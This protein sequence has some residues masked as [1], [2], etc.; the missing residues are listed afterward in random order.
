M[1]FANY[2]MIY[3][4]KSKIERKN[5]LYFYSYETKMTIK[6]T[7]FKCLKYLI[8]VQI[9]WFIIGVITFCVVD[10]TTQSGQN[11]AIDRM[12]NHFIESAIDSSL[13]SQQSSYQLLRPLQP[14]KHQLL[15]RANNR[16]IIVD[17]DDDR[18]ETVDD[19]D[20]DRRETIDDDDDPR[21]PR[22]EDPI[23]KKCI[24]DPFAECVYSDRS[25]KLVVFLLAILIGLCGCGRCYAGFICCG[26]I[27]AVTL[28]GLGIWIL[29]DWIFVLTGEWSHSQDGCC[30]I[31][32]L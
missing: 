16:T 5:H 31:G 9:I 7:I 6:H 10:L 19:D 27:K 1:N 28:G 20:D 25:S 29:I 2:H 18:R 30:F 11:I 13:L 32:D 14:I 26:I 23:A 4:I 24:D 17:D 3:V 8:A 12:H 22:G 15:K 21:V